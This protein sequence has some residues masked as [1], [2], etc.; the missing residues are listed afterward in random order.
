LVRFLSAADFLVLIAKAVDRITGV[1]DFV[2]RHISE[3]ASVFV[4]R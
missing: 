3:T 2:V 1:M 4:L